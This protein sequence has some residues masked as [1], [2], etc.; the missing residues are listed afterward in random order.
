MTAAFEAERAL[1][2]APEA[3]IIDIPCACQA[4]DL[5]AS[6]AGAEIVAITELTATAIFENACG[7][8]VK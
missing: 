2:R 6:H 3:V 5:L 1:T 4:I 7:Q 8:L